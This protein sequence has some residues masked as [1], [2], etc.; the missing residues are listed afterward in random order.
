MFR[1]LL[2]ADDFPSYYCNSITVDMHLS[3]VNVGASGPAVNLTSEHIWH[4]PAVCHCEHVQ[5]PVLSRMGWERL[6][7]ADQ[8]L[9]ESTETCHQIDNLGLATLHTFLLMCQEVNKIC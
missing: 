2:Q 8:Q 6:R 7:H 1:L 4:L 3:A 9:P 5:T